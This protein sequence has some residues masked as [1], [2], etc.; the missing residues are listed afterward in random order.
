[1]KPARKLRAAVLSCALLATNAA[2][3]PGKG[4][5]RPAGKPAAAQAA[6]A[7]AG[8]KKSDVQE[9]TIAVVGATVYTG[10]GE[11][12]ED[13]VVLMAGGEITAV[14][15]GLAVPA[16]AETVQAKGMVV[17]PGLVDPTT[18]V[19]IREVDL[20]PSA[21]DESASHG[22][23]RIRRPGVTRRPGDIHGQRQRR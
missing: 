12:I 21:N 8:G 1:M 7:K 9:K 18:Q 10:D 13:A 3:Q 2:A 4:A 19:G 16:G 11:P 22:P 5:A 14:G 17:T 23:D 6:P 20:E 15:K